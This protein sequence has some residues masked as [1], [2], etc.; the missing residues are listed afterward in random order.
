VT[1]L[2]SDIDALQREGEKRLGRAV[3][4]ALCDV[5]VLAEEQADRHA[6]RVIATL[7]P[8]L[9]SYRRGLEAS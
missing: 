2:R 8:D 9:S 1:L 5:D 3:S 7:H 4:S 6:D